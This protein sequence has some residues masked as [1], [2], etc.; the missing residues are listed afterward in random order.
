MHVFFSL[1]KAYSNTFDCRLHTISTSIP[2]FPFFQNIS[3]Y[4]IGLI[5]QNVDKAN[6]EITTLQDDKTQTTDALNTGM[7]F[8]RPQILQAEIMFKMFC[9]GIFV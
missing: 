3:A 4:I 7:Y 6:E 5:Q 8:L 1:S 2:K 9:S